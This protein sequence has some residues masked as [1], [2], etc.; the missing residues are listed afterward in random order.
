MAMAGAS[1]EGYFRILRWPIILAAVNSLASGVV[2]DWPLGDLAY[3]AT[4]VAILV[5]A[6]W[7][8]IHGGLTNLW[9]VALAGLLL[10]FID[11]PVIRGGSFLVTGETMGFYGVLISF[12]M[13]APV[14]MIV[15]A[16]SGYVIRRRLNSVA[17]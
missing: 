2:F 15:A 3:N 14:P 4:R 8:L 17:I 5:Y 16:A 12:V 7:V 10:S 13:F 1:R 6:A 11:H 9:L